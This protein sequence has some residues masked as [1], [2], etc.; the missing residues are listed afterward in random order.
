VVPRLAVEVIDVRTVVRE[1]TEDGVERPLIQLDA[2][3]RAG[4]WVRA[5]CRIE[6]SLRLLCAWVELAAH[7]PTDAQHA[8]MLSALRRASAAVHGAFDEAREHSAVNDAHAP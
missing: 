3:G 2:L 6:M 8:E 1:A 5:T 7:T 4:D